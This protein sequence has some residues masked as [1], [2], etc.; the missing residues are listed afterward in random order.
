MPEPGYE[1]QSRIVVTAGDVARISLEPPSGVASPVPPA[2]A[3]W[4]KLVACAI[5]TVFPV[6]CLFAIGIRVGVRGRERRVREAWNSLL[7]TLLIVSGLGTFVAA[8][9]LWAVPALPG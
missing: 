9:W 1:E 7:C 8:A 5:A 6:L 4:V 3:W 2:I